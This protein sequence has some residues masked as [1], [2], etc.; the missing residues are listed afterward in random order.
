ML[1]PRIKKVL[2]YGGGFWL[3]CFVLSQFTLYWMRKD[4]PPFLLDMEDHLAE[5]PRVVARIGA[6]AENFEYNYNIHDLEK[7]TLSY[8]FS[9]YGSQG[10]LKIEG[11]AVKKQNQWVP[12]K[13]D[14]LF[15]SSE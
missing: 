5:N 3:F 11:Y 7:D 8:T 13:A 6:D 4:T 12:V 9:L 15:I 10:S 2:V 1:S 14:T